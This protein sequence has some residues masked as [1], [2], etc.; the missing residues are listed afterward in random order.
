METFFSIGI[1]ILVPFPSHSLLFLFFSFFSFFSFFLFFFSFISFFFFFF[2]H[3]HHLQQPPH[4]C[5]RRINPFLWATSV[6]IVSSPST[7]ITHWSVH[8]PS[9]QHTQSP[10]IRM[11]NNGQRRGFIG[12]EI[13]ENEQV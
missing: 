11:V 13:E 5:P 2:F 6:A 7:D 8:P 3:L 1:L 9:A 4:T 10:P 12:R